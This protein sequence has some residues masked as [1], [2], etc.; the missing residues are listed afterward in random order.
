MRYW[1]VNQNQTWR[2]EIRGGYLWSP[3]RNQN[4][5]FNQFYVNMREAE[6]GDLVFSYFDQQVRYVGVV[7][8]TAFS[9]AKPA[10]FDRVGSN[11]G[12]DGWYVPVSWSELPQTIRPK[13]LIEELRPHLP[14]KYS[15]LT[16]SGDGLQSVYLAAVPAGMAAILLAQVP[17]FATRV[18]RRAEDAAPDAGPKERYDRVLERA[19]LNDTSI[20]ETEKRAIVLARRGQGKFRRNLEAVEAGCRVCGVTDRRLLRASHIKP[21]RSCESNNER[22]DGHNGLLLAPHADHLF[23][24]G[25]ISFDGSGAVLV[26]GRIASAQ[27]RL[28]GVGEN[29]NVG[30]FRPEQQRY[31]EYH[32]ENVFLS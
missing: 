11:W 10:E 8:D 27:L 22:L 28:L 19:I 13:A 6:I 30:P 4:G 9:A 15:P 14:A 17:E 18:S 3:K 5:A 31:L 1:W 26:S 12:R 21:W 29:S 25:Y 7:R 2:H 32:R 16:G 24:R 20:P 23:D